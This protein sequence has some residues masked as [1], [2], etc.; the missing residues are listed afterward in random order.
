MAIA[1]AI[2]QCRW[3]RFAGKR[4]KKLRELQVFDDASRGP[5]GSLMLLYHT[6]LKSLAVL[7]ATLTIVSLGFDPFVQSLIHTDVRTV[8]LNDTGASLTAVMTIVDPGKSICLAWS[9]LDSTQVYDSV[10]TLIEDYLDGLSAAYLTAAISALADDAPSFKNVPTCPSKNCTWPTYTTIR[11]C[12]SCKN[13]TSWVHNRYL[14][15]TRGP[16]FTDPDDEL[17]GEYLYTCLWETPQP[18]DN[19]ALS[20]ASEYGVISP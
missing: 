12:S 8:Y 20:Y 2:G 18:F 6:R 9:N 3:L 16:L 1:A 4:P 17:D 14:G 13:I 19:Y 15:C 7:G 5:L 10:L 11:V